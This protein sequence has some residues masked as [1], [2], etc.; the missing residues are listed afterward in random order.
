MMT[1]SWFE[2]DCKVCGYPVVCTQATGSCCDYAYYCSST[3]CR[4][5]VPE[6]VID[7]DPLP[8]WIDA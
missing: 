1:L 8:D 5:H 7:Q 3:S 2:G 6:E 4:H